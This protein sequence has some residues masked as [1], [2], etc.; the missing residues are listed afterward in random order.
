M[1][2]PPPP[3]RKQ[4]DVRAIKRINDDEMV[5]NLVGLAMDLECNNVSAVVE[6]Y[7][8]NYLIYL[9]SMKIIQVVHV[10]KPVNDWRIDDMLALKI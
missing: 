8:N 5:V 3:D 7:D 1:Y 4:I 10:E 6:K 9:T 2:S